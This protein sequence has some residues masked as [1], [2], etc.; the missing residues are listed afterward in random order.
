MID[1]GRQLCTS[2]PFWAGNYLTPRRRNRRNIRESKR[3]RGRYF[4]SAEIG[5]E[6]FIETVKKIEDFWLT[7]VKLSAG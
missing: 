3:F 1:G 2:V 7:V 5:V 6:Q 4:D